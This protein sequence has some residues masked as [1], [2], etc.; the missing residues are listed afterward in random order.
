MLYGYLLLRSL[1]FLDICDS[2][3]RAKHK[4]MKTLQYIALFLAACAAPAYAADVVRNVVEEPVRTPDC[5]ITVQMGAVELDNSSEAS[6]EV[7][8]Y[9]I[10]GTRVAGGRVEGH[11]DVRF[12][13]AAGCYI[14]RAG[15]T[16]ARIMVK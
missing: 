15:T 5:T 12:E 2:F 13:L 3:V 4:T 11:S 10:T 7:E 8:I 16:T 1:P 9:A 6:A 14:V